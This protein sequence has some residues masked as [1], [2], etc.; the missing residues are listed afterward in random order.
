MWCHGALQEY[1]SENLI[2]PPWWQEEKT[3][4]EKCVHH[5]GTVTELSYAAEWANTTSA[6]QSNV[7]HP[8]HTTHHIAIHWSHRSSQSFHCYDTNTQHEH[9]IIPTPKVSGKA[10]PV[11]A[12][13]AYR[14]SEGTALLIPNLGTVQR[15]VVCLMPQTLYPQQEHPGYPM[16]RR[17]GEPQIPPKHFGE[18]K[19]LVPAAI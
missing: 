4:A 13:K 2:S 3:T 6:H 15:W 9:I 11:H 16:H 8:A 17:V 14:G 7:W 12:M 5:N 19:S 18:E 10:V 1:I